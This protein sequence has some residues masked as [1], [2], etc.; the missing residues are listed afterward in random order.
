MGNHLDTNQKLS[1]SFGSVDIFQ[2]VPSVGSGVNNKPNL[3][4]YKSTREVW[5]NPQWN[6]NISELVKM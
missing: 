5:W 6:N 1:A 2:I 3:Q 4:L